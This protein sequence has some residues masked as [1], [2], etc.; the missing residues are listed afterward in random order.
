MCFGKFQ[1]LFNNISI[2]LIF[3]FDPASSVKKQSKH[4]ANIEIQG[5]LALYKNIE[6]YSEEI[7]RYETMLEKE[8]Y[9]KSFTAADVQELL[10]ELEKKS[11]KS[12]ENDSSSK[13]NTIC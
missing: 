6:N 12:G 4:L 2:S 9:E 10:E 13:N 11:K 3:L 1:F 7:A 8:Q 5:I